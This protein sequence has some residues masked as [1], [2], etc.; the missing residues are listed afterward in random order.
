MLAAASLRKSFNPAVAFFVIGIPLYFY[1][2]ALYYLLIFAII[3]IDKM[4]P[5]HISGT[6]RALYRVFVAP[7]LRTPT[8]IPLLWAPA[9]A[10]HQAHPSSPPSLTSHTTIRTKVYKKD[11]ARHALTDHYVLDSAIRSPHINFVDDNGIFHPNMPIADALFRVN[12][13]THYLVQVTPGAVDEYGRQDPNDLPTCRMVTKMALREQHQRKLE[14]ARRQAKGISAGPTPKNLELNWAIAGG[15]LKH[16]LGKL[17]E[18]LREGRKVEVLLAPK[19]KGRQGTEEEANNLVKAVRD[20]VLD[21]KGAKE[22]KSEGAIGGVLTLTFEGGK[23]ELKKKK[24]AKKAEKE[25]GKENVAD[26]P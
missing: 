8:S 9:F 12:Q 1:I 23:E 25:A 4:P 5:T 21:C 18:F 24:E 14:L 3:S 15:D 22:V 20:A 11:I 7:T 2:R 10:S 26:T 13:L 6:S 16:R 17:H 19:K